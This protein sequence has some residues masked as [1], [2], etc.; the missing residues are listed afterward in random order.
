[1]HPIRRFY[2]WLRVV[3]LLAEFQELDVGELSLVEA[4]PSRSRVALGKDFA[5]FRRQAFLISGFDLNTFIDELR[6]ERIRE[7]MSW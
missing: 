4:R 6:E 2:H 7:L 3:C 1:M 5:K